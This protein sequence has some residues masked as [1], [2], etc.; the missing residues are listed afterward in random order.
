MLG[1]TGTHDD[2]SYVGEQSTSVFSM[3]YYRNKAREFQDMLNHVDQAAQAAQSAIDA[4]IDPDLSSGLQN[5]LNEFAMRKFTFRAAAEGI[6]AGAALINS[7]GGRMPQLSVPSGLGI[8]PIVLPAAAIAA[9]GVAAALIVWGSQWIAGVNARLRD[10][11][12]LENVTD[13]TKRAA[14]ASAI[15][16]GEAAAA[17]AN[18][19]PLSSIAGIVKWAA[20]A[21]AAWMAYRALSDR[22]LLG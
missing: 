14:L 16:Q 11:Q 8:A 3:D 1:D 19:S 18:E 17:L 13:P 7:A 4:D 2:E 21:I 15:A 20:I 22:K 6:N 5:M 12:L 10:A 9:F